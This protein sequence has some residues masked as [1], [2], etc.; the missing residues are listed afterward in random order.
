MPIVGMG[1]YITF[2][3][4]DDTEALQQRIQVL[5]AFFEAGGK[6]IDSSPMYDSS[7]AALGQ[8]LRGL[9][10]PT[11]L[12]AATKVWHLFTAAG[13]KQMENSR[14]LWGNPGFDLMQVHNRRDMDARRD[15]AREPA[16]R[17]GG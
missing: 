2:D 14:S 3:I 13:D 8:A 5:S 7:E 9:G 12:F 17:A 16:R 1:S 10:H 11:D 6:L 15:R 4:G